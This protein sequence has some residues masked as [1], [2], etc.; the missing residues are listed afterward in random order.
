MLETLN[1]LV[2][3]VLKWGKTVILLKK[4]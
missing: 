2:L 4:C 1:N 3:S